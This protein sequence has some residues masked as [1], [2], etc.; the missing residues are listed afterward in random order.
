MDRGILEFVLTSLKFNWNADVP[1]ATISPDPEFET[2]YG[3][4]ICNWKWIKWLRLLKKIFF[5]GAIDHALRIIS[6]A[7]AGAGSI[8]PVSWQALHVHALCNS[9]Y[10]GMDEGCD[11]CTCFSR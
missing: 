8:V 5:T 1:T 2:A 11:E 10:H 9:K 4:N 3:G 6:R 7:F